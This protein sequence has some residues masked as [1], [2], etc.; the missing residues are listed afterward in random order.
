MTDLNRR[1]FLGA[2]AAAAWSASSY[3]QITGANNRLRIGV[4]GCGGMAGGHMRSL[5]KNKDA[6]NAAIVAVCDIYD[7]RAQEAAALTGAPI[8]K[9]YRRLVDSKEI[10]Y[11]LIATPE[12]WHCQ[13]T[14]DALDAG[15]HVYVEKPMT[16]TID[17]AK[18][19][20]AKVKSSGRKLQVG[21]QGMSD[22]SYDSA[23]QL[24]K[25]GA[26]GKVVLAQIDYS[27]NH[28]DDF[29]MYDIDPDARPG[30][31]LDWRAWLGPAKKRDWD[32]ER[33]F[34]WRRY[35]DYSGGIATDLFVHRATRL[36]KALNLKY[37]ETVVA[38]GGKWEFTSSIAEI[39]DTFDVLADY[40]GGPTMQLVSSMANDTPV[41]HMLRGHK[42]TLTFTKTGYTV[43]PQSLFKEEAKEV[44]F[45]KSG[46]ESVDL[47][48]QNLQAA[49]RDKAALNCDMMLG[50]Y[51]VVV[52]TMAVESFRKRQYLLWDAGH[53]RARKA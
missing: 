49:I 47:H 28:K 2:T 14:L 11:V 53:Q 15:K 45:T 24:V 46:A 31:N 50:Y 13:M 21:V 6:N 51:G 4:I 35:W 42:A 34:R 36:I 22:N 41:E 43:T 18:K 10:D 3:A 8:I 16:H 38:T 25:S 12:H 33:Y 29:W 1:A 32:P 40:P 5:V 26:L 48:H 52:C 37:P 19:V 30:V 44:T 39:P 9:D 27:R 17:E 7:K 23:W 20:V